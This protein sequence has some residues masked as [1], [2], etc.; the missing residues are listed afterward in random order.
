MNDLALDGNS[1]RA[2]ET[3][4]QKGVERQVLLGQKSYQLSESQY[5]ALN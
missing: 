1:P 4:C 5:F 2:E 3:S